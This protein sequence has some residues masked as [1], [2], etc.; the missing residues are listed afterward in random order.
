MAPGE[1]PTTA[2]EG[3]LTCDEGVTVGVVTDLS[4]G[5]QLSGRRTAAGIKIGFSYEAGGSAEA[6]VYRI[7]DCDIRVVIA[8]DQSNH[9]VAEIAAKD[10][11]VD[12]GASVLIG[13]STSAGTAKLQEVA[14]EH[15]VVL[16]ALVDTPRGL[17]GEGFDPLSFLLAP[18]E[19][20][21][22]MTNCEHAVA[23][24]RSSFALVA[25]DCP[26]GRRAAAAYR[27]SCEW[28]GG[29]VTGDVLLPA[30][31]A[32][33]AEPLSSLSAA[34]VMMITWPTPEV[35]RLLSDALERGAV[36][37]S[38]PSNDLVPLL[39]AGATG[40]EGVTP[41]LPNVTGSEVDDDLIAGSGGKPD[42]VDAQGMIAAQLVVAA[43][44]SSGGDAA[45]LAVALEG[46]AVATAN[47]S[48]QL[49][50]QDHLLIQNMHAARLVDPGA[51]YEHL[52]TYRPEPP[53]ILAGEHS[54]RCGDLPSSLGD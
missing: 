32:D 7:A 30:G 11:V 45:R 21:V 8:D 17:T 43:L 37:T 26:A 9:E 3:R 47:G 5:L 25:M 42:W 24:G 49:R 28:F 39:F 22:A 52:A 48:V 18:S 41:Y 4:G 23:S 31:S 13:A 38:F 19:Y 20:Q 12:H 14:V 40:V 1:P 27:D 54:D 6:D 33:F 44:R 10:L 34:D 51:V 53:C 15:D 2:S 46:L 36:A 35:N 16:L 29:E 50:A